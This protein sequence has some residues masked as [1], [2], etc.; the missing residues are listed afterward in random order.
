MRENKYKLIFQF[1]PPLGLVG[2]SREL[3]LYSQSEAIRQW[4]S[5]SCFHWESA[6]KAWGE[7]HFY[8]TYLKWVLHVCHSDI[9]GPSG[10]LNMQTQPAQV[11][12]QQEDY[13]LGKIKYDPDTHNTK[14]KMFCTSSVIPRTRKNTTQMGKDS[15]QL[16]TLRWIRCRNQLTSMLVKAASWKCFSNQLGILLKWIRK[17]KT[18]VKK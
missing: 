6:S 8:P 4:L 5:V 7:W 17:W 18:S 16:P 3:S 14:S 13:P 2:P 1:S 12:P 10:K 15:Q 9:G 11:V